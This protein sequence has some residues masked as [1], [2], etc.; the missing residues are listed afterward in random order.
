L[1]QLPEP[2]SRSESHAGH[3]GSPWRLSGCHGNPI[4]SGLRATNREV[5]RSPGASPTGFRTTPRTVA[6]SPDE[7]GSARVAPDLSAGPT[8]LRGQPSPVAAVAPVRS[9]PIQAPR[10]RAAFWE[11]GV[12]AEVLVLAAYVRCR[13]ADFDLDDSFITYTYAR[14]LASG[15]G[16]TFAGQK[17]L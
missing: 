12:L 15:H 17:V 8:D 4:A 7:I 1:L 14:S 6:R 2:P 16:F 9:S 10:A 11:W 13:W 3:T 5:Y